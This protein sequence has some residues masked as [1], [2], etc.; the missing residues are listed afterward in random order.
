MRLLH[1]DEWRRLGSQ[2]G[3]SEVKQHKWFAKLNWGLLRNTRPPVR[4]IPLP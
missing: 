3:A 4:T 2:S 1:K